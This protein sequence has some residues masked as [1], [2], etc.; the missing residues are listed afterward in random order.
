MNL[1]KHCKES[2]KDHHDIY[3][4]H[5][6]RMTNVLII[7]NISLFFVSNLVNTDGYFY[8]YISL[9]FLGLIGFGILLPVGFFDRLSYYLFYLVLLFISNYFLVSSIVYWIQT[10]PSGG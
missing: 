10:T 6:S 5:L 7:V 3:W 8:T 1:Y 4:A 9:I 2:F